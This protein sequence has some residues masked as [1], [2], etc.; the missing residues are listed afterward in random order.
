M[1]RQTA[2]AR[3]AR[4][5]SGMTA[6]IVIAAVLSV[7]LNTAVAEIARAAGASSDFAPLHLQTYTPW[8]VLGVLAGFV[9]WAVVRARACRPRR[10]MRMLVPTVV[11]NSWT[12]DFI[13][14]FNGGLDGT[15]WGAVSALMIMHVVVGAV[16]VTI[17]IRLLPLPADQPSRNGR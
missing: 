13:L 14:G 9:G 11:S 6:G 5:S 16:V 15:S 2:T 10:L 3:T 4:S 12:P 8:T 1:T 17:C 7:A